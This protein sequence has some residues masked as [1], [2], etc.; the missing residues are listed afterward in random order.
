MRSA[1]A[2]SCLPLL[3]PSIIFTRAASAWAV[4]STDPERLDFFDQR[5]ANH[6]GIGQS[7]KRPETWPGRE[8][9]KPIA[10]GKLGDAPHA[11]RESRQ[12]VS[13]LI[14]RARDA[15]ARKSGTVNPLDDFAISAN[16]RS[17]EK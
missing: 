9:P 1:L 13:E 14:L 12:L 15:R 4:A 3:R 11:P 2:G 5:R 7:S 8:I 6:R 10:I 16:R 17:V